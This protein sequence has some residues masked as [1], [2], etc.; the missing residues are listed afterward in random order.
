M[1]EGAKHRVL[2]QPTSRHA[3]PAA[4]LQARLDGALS[5]L[6]WWEGSLPT[7]GGC[8]RELGKGPSNQT[9]L[10]FPQP[11]LLRPGLGTTAAGARPGLRCLQEEACARTLMRCLLT[12]FVKVF[13]WTRSRSSAREEKA[14]LS[15]QRKEQGKPPGGLAGPPPPRG[16]H[17]QQ[18]AMSQPRWGTTVSQPARNGKETVNVNQP[19]HGEQHR[20]TAGRGCARPARGPAGAGGRRDR[21]ARPRA[22]PCTLRETANGAGMSPLTA[23]TDT[24][25]GAARTAWGR[26]QG[27]PTAPVLPAQPGMQARGERCCVARGSPGLVVPVGCAQGPVPGAGAPRGLPHKAWIPQGGG[28]RG[29]PLLPAA[30]GVPARGALSHRAL[31]APLPCNYG[32]GADAAGRAPRADAARSQAAPR[33]PPGALPAP[34][35]EGLHCYPC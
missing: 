15:V 21:G 17:W 22:P 6:A 35:D 28:S 3:H 20:S 5:E 34:A 9:A 24:A 18:E 19:L 33:A 29:L 31:P 16:R 27:H 7:S 13:F 14:E 23:C 11:T 1:P 30:R 8:S 32:D 26:A 2:L 12:H 25:P 4:G 10:R